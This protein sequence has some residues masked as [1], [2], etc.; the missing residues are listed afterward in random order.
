MSFEALARFSSN[1]IY[2]LTKA[3]LKREH[4][5]NLCKRENLSLEMKQQKQFARL[6]N[7]HSVATVTCA[8]I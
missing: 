6:I 4:H 5:K 1:Y 8:R 2:A 7:K 3:G